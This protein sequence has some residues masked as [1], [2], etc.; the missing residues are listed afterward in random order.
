MSEEPIS[1]DLL[2]PEP[3]LIVISGPSG[4][5]KDT[6]IQELKDRH[7]PFHFVVTATSRLPRFN[8][9]VGVDYFFYSPEEFEHMIER[10]QLIEYAWVY[11]QYKGIPREQVEVAL[12]SGKDVVLRVD[13][14][15]AAKLRSLYPEAVLIFLLPANEHEWRSRLLDRKTETDES[16]QLRVKTV[17]EELEQVG[18]FDYLVV[19]G[20][21]KLEEAVDEV[22][23]IIKA[24]HHRTHPRKILK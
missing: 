8:E 14:Q 18:M 22:E 1:F 7:R 24:E 4:V 15:G 10:N 16:Y 9:V 21:G 2:H 13:V 17:C 20:Q 23:T 19:N 3:L 5:G 11:N 12:A 6:V